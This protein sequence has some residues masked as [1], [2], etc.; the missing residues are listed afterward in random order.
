MQCLTNM[1]NMLQL[2]VWL[3]QVTQLQDKNEQLHLKVKRQASQ[4]TAVL[5]ARSQAHLDL[6]AS[7]QLEIACL[8]STSLTNSTAINKW[9]C[10]CSL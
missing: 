7:L 10:T 6:Q 4:L 2:T 9:L 8:I 3:A 1:Q 5:E